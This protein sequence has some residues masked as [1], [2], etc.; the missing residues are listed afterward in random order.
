MLLYRKILHFVKLG[1]VQFLNVFYL[2]PSA[3]VA[4]MSP[5]WE[6]APNSAYHL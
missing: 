1:A 4:E 5:V 3:K 2:N 6:R